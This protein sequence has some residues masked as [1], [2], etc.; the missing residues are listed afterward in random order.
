MRHGVLPRTLHVDE[1]TPHVDWS[2]GAVE[3]LTEAAP[4]PRRRAA[5]PRGGVLVRHQ[6][7]QRARDPGG[8]A[9]RRRRRPATADPRPRRAAGAGLGAETARRCA[10]QAAPAA[11]PRWPRAGAGRPPT[12]ATRSPTTARAF[13]HRAV[14]LG[15][16]RDELLA[17]LTRVGAGARSRHGRHRRRA[18]AGHGWRS[19]SP[20]RAPSGPAWAASCTPRSR[21][22]R[23]RSTRCCAELD[24]ASRPAAARGHVRRADGAALLTR[25][26]T[27]RP[28]CSRSRSRCSGCSSRWGVRP[29]CRGRA[30]DR[31]DRRRPRRR[32]A[33]PRRRG[34]RWSP[35]GAG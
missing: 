12:S 25:P 16:D 21:S 34:A 10:A 31:R 7:H 20:V 14:V 1:P 6:R 28:A 19:C 18:G 29:D 9:R 30:L 17:G 24:A 27:P 11:R 32:R 3:L 13:E 23:R 2:A 4:W 5:A 35:R 26:P 33:V 22:S 8:A 15:A